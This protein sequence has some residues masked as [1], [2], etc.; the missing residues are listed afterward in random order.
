MSD[1][2]FARELGAEFHRVAQAGA[3]AGRRRGSPSWAVTLTGRVTTALAVAIP[4]V[5]AVVAFALLS[6]SQ[7]AGRAASATPSSATGLALTGGNCRIPA[8]SGPQVSGP[9]PNVV[10]S[11]G[12][13]RITGGEV[14]GIEWQLRGK[15][16]TEALSLAPHTQLVLGG[17]RYGLCSQTA[18]PVPFALLNSGAHGIVF[19]NVPEGGSY[20][21]TVTTAGTRLL[22]T[23]TGFDDEMFFIGALARPACSYRTLTV[24]AAS[25]PAIGGLPP[26]IARSIQAT[27]AHFSST[28]TFGSCRP[29][30]LVTVVS[31]HGQRRGV[32]S[33]VL[34][35]GV[36][37]VS[38]TAPAGAHSDAK[39]DLWELTRDGLRGVELLAFGLRP[40]RYGIWLD[41]AR[42]P[43]TRIGSATITGH[44]ELHSAYDLPAGF[45]GGRVVLAT[46]PS[47][48]TT[49]PGATVLQATLP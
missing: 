11:D 15:L 12:L 8:K 21:I 3:A 38:L 7:R 49:G 13:S 18:L 20:L 39:G 9:P 46:Q 47:G 1:L 34:A 5:I 29:G 28:I 30:A 4:L 33:S 19:G 31:E 45:T 42:T 48:D 16:G 32:L 26:N 36:A 24:S 44:R 17:R 27:T 23:K 35:H 40:G 41:A 10:G 43:P 6:H 14:D 37:Q 22:A 2:R 25:E